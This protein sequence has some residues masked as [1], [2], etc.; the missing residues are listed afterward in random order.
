MKKKRQQC[1]CELIDYARQLI[2]AVKRNDA[3]DVLTT[4][5]NVF[6]HR[7]LDDMP[8]PVNATSAIAG[9]TGVALD[10]IWRKWKESK[11]VMTGDMACLHGGTVDRIE[12]CTIQV[13]DDPWPYAEAHRAAIDEHWAGRSAEQL[14]YFNGTVYVLVSYALTGCDFAAVMRPVEFKSFLYWRAQHFPETGVRDAFG[15]ALI[16]SAEGHVLLGR[17]SA[18]NLNAGLNYLPGGFVDPRDVDCSGRIDI[19]ASVLREALEET[20]LEAADLCRMPGFILTR[21][22]PQVSIGIEFRS[23]LG[24]DALR[25]KIGHHLSQDPDAE[26]SAVEFVT[27]RA[28]IGT[29]AMPPFMTV[30]LRSLFSGQENG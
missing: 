12:R 13:R 18:G 27:S 22:D 6:H 28:G 26:L 4:E 10:A 23:P 5:T 2:I 3:A 14:S 19:A 1:D 11:A 20:G 21:C 24:A 15:S 17:Q 29:T 8:G 30:L 16:R 9:R 7:T 25:A